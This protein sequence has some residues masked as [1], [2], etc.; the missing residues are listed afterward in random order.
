MAAPWRPGASPKNRRSLWYPRLILSPPPIC[1]SDER[2][3]PWH[4][5]LMSNGT[6]ILAVGARR[7][8][9]KPLNSKLV[10]L[11]VVQNQ[12]REQRICCLRGGTRLPTDDLLCLLGALGAFGVG[13]G[14]FFAAHASEPKRLMRTSRTL[15]VLRTKGVQIMVKT[16]KDR[17]FLV[18][19]EPATTVLDVKQRVAEEDPTWEVARQ[20]IIFKGQ[21]LPEDKLIAQCGLDDGAPTCHVVMRLPAPG[22]ARKRRDDASCSSSCSTKTP[23][24]PTTSSSLVKLEANDIDDALTCNLDDLM[25]CADSL[26]M[27]FDTAWSDFQESA[28]SHDSAQWGDT[29]LDLPSSMASPTTALS[30]KPCM[31]REASGTVIME[32]IAIPSSAPP[33]IF[34]D[35]VRPPAPFLPARFV[36]R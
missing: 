7:W 28:T 31:S 36:P 1:L 2:A 8:L 27:E 5:H 25:T 21:E 10:A 30:P 3:R 12:V 35:M 34:S 29:N 18:N 14:I 6:R 11:H 17:L 33:G 24:S 20:R 16:L 9:G 32:A 26:P 19:A 15:Q 4:L 22:S 13:L 23:A